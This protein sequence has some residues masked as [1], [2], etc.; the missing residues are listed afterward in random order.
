MDCKDLTEIFKNKLLVC[1]IAKNNQVNS[2][3]HSCRNS[4]YPKM[5]FHDFHNNFSRK[6]LGIFPKVLKFHLAIIQKF[7]QIAGNH[8]NVSYWRLWWTLQEIS[9]LRFSSIFLFFLSWLQ[10]IRLQFHQVWQNMHVNFTNILSRIVVYCSI[11]AIDI[12]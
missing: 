10:E 9:K 2:S 5:L 3:R 4:L 12:I 6:F 8:K 11:F 1:S 7:L